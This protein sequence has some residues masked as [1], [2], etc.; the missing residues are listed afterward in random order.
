MH[1]DD[2]AQRLVEL[3]ASRHNAFHTNEAASRGFTPDRL[4]RARS[5]GEL[6]QLRPKVWAL[7]G[8]PSNEYQTLR[9]ATLALPGSA[10]M[11][12]SAAWL[13][14]WV[15]DPPPLPQ[16]W[17]PRSGRHALPAAVVH[18]IGKVDPSIDIIEVDGI[19]CLNRAATL[20]QMDQR[21]LVERCLDEFLRNNSEA[22]LRQTVERHLTPRSPGPRMLLD[23]MED[24]RRVGGVTESW[25]ERI[26]AQL[27]AAP[28][29]PVVHLQHPVVVD[30][31][32][33]RID[34]ALP[35]L[36]LGIE[37]HSRTFH[38]GPGTED[39]DNV[40][41]Q[42]LGTAGWQVLY[43]TWAQLR[44][45]D[46]FVDRVRAIASQRLPSVGG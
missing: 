9:A 22:W 46:E 15:D 7:T 13:H 2:A 35:D 32:S 18:R 3:A 25:M 44:Q 40:R 34:V 16:L 14:G 29:L 5:R 41:D 31:R 10:A 11:G 6:Y 24:E 43:V 17:A 19:R 30:G 20:C 45:P 1:F 26:V 37:A 12:R 28:D 4:R 21:A 36:R 42:L 8:G 27:I 23:V 33:F 39:A 38:W